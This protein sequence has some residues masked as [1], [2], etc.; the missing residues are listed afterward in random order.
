MLVGQSGSGKSTIIGLI[1][2]FYDPVRGTIKIDGR[3]LKSYN[4]RALRKYIGMVGQEP[5]LFAGSIRE[6]ITY[7][8]NGEKTPIEIEA[9]AR[10]ANAH[11]FISSLMDGYEMQ[12]DDRGLQLS[13]G[14]KQLIA[15]ARAIL[16]D[17]AILLLDEAT[18]ALDSQ[19]EEVVL[20]ALERLMV[21]RTSVVV[22]H[23][24][25]TIRHCHLITILD[26]GAVVENGTHASLMSKGPAGA[27]FGLLTLQS[28][29]ATSIFSDYFCC[30]FLAVFTA[31]PTGENGATRAPISIDLQRDSSLGT[32]SI[33]LQIDSKSQQPLQFCSSFDQAAGDQKSLAAVQALLL[34]QGHLYCRYSL[35]C[36]DW[37]ICFYCFGTGSMDLLDLK[38][39]LKQHGELRLKVLKLYLLE[40]HKISSEE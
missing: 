32:K 29:G 25:S 5:T 34:S 28:G 26:Q 8:S 21:G 1:H 37:S 30:L 2:R 10:A 11:E 9:A 20:A 14:Q 19:S 7:G 35:G 27:Y 33:V 16:K 23:R 18:S 38:V 40:L 36:S 3:V 22:A 17:L 31:S 4:L 39:H 12:C 13:G 24:L 15:I 6:N